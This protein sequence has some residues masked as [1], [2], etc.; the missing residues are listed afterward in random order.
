MLQSLSV[1]SSLRGKTWTTIPI[2]VEESCG[3]RDSLHDKLQ[4]F[5]AL[6]LLFEGHA[7]T[8]VDVDDDVVKSE[9]DNIHGDLTRDPPRSDQLVYAL[10]GALGSLLDARVTRRVEALEALLLDGLLELLDILTDVLRGRRRRWATGELA[11]L[12]LRW[13]TVLLTARWSLRRV[14][15]L[16][17]WWRRAARVGLRSSL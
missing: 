17:A 8:V 1:T 16:L 5:D 12:L 7:S 3:E 2:L 11:L 15:L 13:S 9:A 10:R 14:L 6:A 4:V